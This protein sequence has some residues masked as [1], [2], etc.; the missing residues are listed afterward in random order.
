MNKEGK[1]A[2]FHEGGVDKFKPYF[3]KDKKYGVE[4]WSINIWDGEQN[5]TIGFFSKD[6]GHEALV[7]LIGL[8]NKIRNLRQLREISIDEITELITE[9]YSSDLPQKGDPVPDLLIEGQGFKRGYG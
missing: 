8:V 2:E 6:D 9:L 3:T 5:R 7:I 1:A 4:H